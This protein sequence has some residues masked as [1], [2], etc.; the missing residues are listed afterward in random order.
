MGN[1]LREEERMTEDALTPNDPK[2]LTDEEL[3][4]VA[5]G[6]YAWDYDSEEDMLYVYDQVKQS[7]QYG[8]YSYEEFVQYWYRNHPD[9]LKC[10][11]AWIAGGKPKDKCYVIGEDGVMTIS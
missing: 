7:H 10:R 5:G 3:S 8:R 11:D 1:A 2:K 4:A 9:C 6:G